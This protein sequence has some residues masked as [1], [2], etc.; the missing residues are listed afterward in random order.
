MIENS[1]NV[2]IN[3]RIW[4]RVRVRAQVGGGGWLEDIDLSRPVRAFAK[5]G[6]GST[7]RRLRRLDEF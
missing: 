2:S 3:K 5:T 1:G 6:E 4:L 7:S